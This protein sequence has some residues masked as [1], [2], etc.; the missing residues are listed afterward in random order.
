MNLS[1]IPEYKI[2]AKYVKDYSIPIKY[3]M[4]M[5]YRY[6]VLIQDKY[7]VES[8][9]LP[10]NI[11]YIINKYRS[12][13]TTMN[14]DEC[15]LKIY[16]WLEIV[17]SFYGNKIILVECIIWQEL[18]SKKSCKMFTYSNLCAILDEIE[19]KILR[20]TMHAGESIG[21]QTASAI[22]AEFTQTALDK[23]H[24]AANLGN[25]ATTDMSTLSGLLNFTNNPK[26]ESLQELIYFEDK[27]KNDLDY[28]IGISK[29]F[30]LG[31]IKDIL[32]NKNQIYDPEFFNGI[33]IINKDK[34]ALSL[35]LRYNRVENI[36]I[37]NISIRLEFDK[38]KLHNRKINITDVIYQIISKYSEIYI[39]QLSTTILRLYVNTSLINIK[40]YKNMS[41]VN[42]VSTIYK[43]IDDIQIS[44]IENIINVRIDTINTLKY[45][46]ISRKKEIDKEYIL[47]TTGSNYKETLLIP[48]IDKRR[49]ITNNISEI[50][51]MFG[52]E[53]MRRVL[54]E[55]IIDCVRSNGSDIN[56]AYPHTQVDF[57]TFN[58]A[59]ISI[60]PHGLRKAEVDPFQ[61]ITL[62]EE[63]KEFVNAS[64]YGL[65]DHMQN[66][67]ASTLV[68]QKAR[69]SSGMFNLMVDY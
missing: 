11:K 42:A 47:Y 14:R 18:A 52:I 65:T 26:T 63:E 53:A 7:R 55:R 24:G 8:V 23:F 48:G 66:V 10:F 36:T 22:S 2:L 64:L 5:L 28:V 6:M 3:E 20:G 62:E 45:D 4:C 40:K 30:E 43:Y 51:E 59:K 33:T 31:F 57:M 38:A 27:Y 44:G 32:K 68:C 50:E 46:P 15:I 19:R 12:K 39:I 1:E 60:N 34:K 9:Q 16:D 17:R 56:Y 58:S 25:K 21:I 49:T 13:K 67:G 41:E 37:S 29:K 69:L 54:L 61:R 35:Y